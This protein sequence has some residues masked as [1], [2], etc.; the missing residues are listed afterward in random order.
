MQSVKLLYFSKT[1]PTK[2]LLIHS[3]RA[4][5]YPVKDISLKQ[6]SCIKYVIP[7]IQHKQFRW[8]YKQQFFESSQMTN[9]N[10]TNVPNHHLIYPIPYHQSL[11]KILLCPLIKSN[12]SKRILY[13]CLMETMVVGLFRPFG[14]TE[15]MIVH[16]IRR[17]RKQLEWF[18][19]QSLK[20]TVSSWPTL[21][22]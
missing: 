16:F 11:H 5:S 12:Q 22:I 10:R 19:V 9:P 20:L 6:H 1:L 3:R 17:L 2:Q 18:N 8:I 14:T 4:K 7:W 13:L 21:Q 15:D